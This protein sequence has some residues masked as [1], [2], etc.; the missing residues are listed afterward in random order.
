M[1]RALRALRGKSGKR[2][3]AGIDRSRAV[4]SKPKKT[5]GPSNNTVAHA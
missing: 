4:A 1:L 2:Q 5:Q 3:N